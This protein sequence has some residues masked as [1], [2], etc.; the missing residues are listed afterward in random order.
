MAKT[1]DRGSGELKHHRVLTVANM[2]AT[3]ALPIQILILT[4]SR[5]PT[6]P[7]QL[8]TLLHQT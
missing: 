8:R 1:S 3:V 2:G 7:H 4:L 6:L 5:S